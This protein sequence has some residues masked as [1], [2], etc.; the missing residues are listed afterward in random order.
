[1]F[2]RRRDSFDSP[3]Y[4]V[5]DVLTDDLFVDIN[6][7]RKYNGLFWLKDHGLLYAIKY[8]PLNKGYTCGART[9]IKLTTVELLIGLTRLST[10]LF[11]HPLRD[12]ST[13]ISLLATTPFASPARV[14]AT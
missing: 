1:M 13:L 6:L 8:T 3:M 9:L 11:G 10:S 4:P 5:W 7:K 14:P 2:E 12:W